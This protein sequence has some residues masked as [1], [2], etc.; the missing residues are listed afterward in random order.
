MGEQELDRTQRALQTVDASKRESLRKLVAGAVFVAPVVV[1]FAI[2]GL[3]VGAL[4]SPVP[5]NST[6]S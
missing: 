2:D 4:A 5:I 3:T 1:S 6:H